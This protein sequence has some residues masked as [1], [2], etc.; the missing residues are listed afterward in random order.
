VTRGQLRLYEIEHVDQLPPFLMTVVGD[1]DLWMYL[2]STGGL[3]AGRVEPERCLFP[4]ETDDRLHHAAGLSGPVTV[5]R[6]SDGSQWRPFDNRPLPAG[7]ARRLFRSAVGDLVI[8]EESDDASG[9]TFSSEWAL[10]DRFGIVRTCTIRLDESSAPVSVELIDG[11]INVMP[12]NVPLGLQQGSSTLV[13]AYKR[14]EYD[15]ETGLATF[16]LEAAISDRPEPSESLRANAVWR[17]GLQDA[18]VSVDPSAVREFERGG[19]VQPCSISTGRRGAYLCGAALSLSPGGVERW[20][21]ACDTH[22]DH[23]DVERLSVWLASDQDRMPSVDGDIAAGRDRLGAL[24]DRADGSQVT[25]DESATSAH[26]SN[27][28]FNAMRGGIPADGYWV[29]I[30]D[31]RQFLRARH[32][33]IANRHDPELSELGDRV[34]LADLIQLA[35]DSKDAQLVRLAMEYLPLT[36][37]RRHGD[38]SRPW[39]RFRIRMKTPDGAKALGYE[40]NWRDIFQNWE[41]LSVSY[42][43]FLPSMVAKFVNAS[44]TDGHNPY[45]ISNEGIDWETLD[46]ADPWSNIGYWGDHQ[47]VYL[48]R[49]LERLR[50]TNPLALREMLEEPVFSYANVPYRIRS[51]EDIVANPR[52]SLRF[53]DEMDKELRSQARSTGSDAKLVLDALGEPVLVTLLEKLLVPALA[54]VSNLVPG[55]GIW[56]NLQRP[57]WN[58]ANNALA[59]YGLSMVTLY[60]LRSYADFVSELIAGHE[61]LLT[62]M[63]DTV[64]AWC[65]SVTEE[66][67]LWSDQGAAEADPAARW[68]FLSAVGK[69]AEHARDR[70]GERGLGP[71][72]TLELASIGRFFE[73]TK[74]MC[75]RT[76]AGAQRADGLYHSYNVLGIDAA[77]GRAA[78]SHLHL[79]LEGNVAVLGAGVL[80]ATQ[81]CDLVEALFDSDLYRPDQRTFMLAPLVDRPAFAERNVIPEAAIRE[82]PLLERILEQ[83]MQQIAV[84]DRAGNARF[85]PELVTR[86]SLDA[87]LE[88]LA[89]VP[90]WEALVRD[91]AEGVRAAYE[92][93]FEHARFTGR[94]GT[95]HKYEGIG[96]VYWHMV[97]KLLLATQESLFRLDPQEPGFERCAKAYRRVRDGLGPS[98]TPIE[99]G[100]VPHEPYSH[101]PWGAGAQQPGMTG[102]VKEG[103]ICRLREVGVQFCAGQI[104]FVQKVPLESEMLDEPKTWRLES[105][106]AHSVH[107]PAGSIG[108]TVCGVPVVRSPAD[109]DGVTLH[110]RDGNRVEFESTRL[111]ARWSREVFGRTGEVRQIE[112]RRRLG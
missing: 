39:N 63:S 50:D 38:P 106:G 49:L 16:C 86:E 64:A 90:G 70:I 66:L 69:H 72:T 105:D 9:L 101:T 23:G 37:G 99:F 11:L 98:K 58:D 88:Q 36:F 42:P 2:S 95:M 76:I 77:E 19:A 102:Q 89:S 80:D 51:F 78:V 45:R 84:R 4:Y 28:L 71:R 83:G 75:D 62:Q 46:P 112:V 26:R 107:L 61:G 29:E 104:E 34:L 60:Q 92:L 35:R 109:A 17:S 108:F 68:Q 6:F 7:R 1:S 110:L 111:D 20:A 30:A 14:S 94:S 82:S 81:S 43:D 18:A 27:V 44:T 15:P 32:E 47:L 3:T 103:V 74:E 40:G 22:L 65:R 100:A 10:S 52:A 97:S 24:L 93:T 85:G 73:L 59:G 79:M 5:I 48:H 21:L 91:D 54:K 87:R 8:F 55:G 67:S 33:G 56:M 13:D 31:F 12:A 41:A 53:D 25:A 96:S 57:E